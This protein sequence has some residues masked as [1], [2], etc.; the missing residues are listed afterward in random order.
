MR[1]TKTKFVNINDYEEIS[2]QQLTN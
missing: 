2:T 1:I